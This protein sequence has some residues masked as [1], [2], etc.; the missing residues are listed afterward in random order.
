MGWWFDPLF[1][2]CCCWNWNYRYP[3]QPTST[4]IHLRTSKKARFPH[5]T[6]S[7]GCS[8]EMEIVESS[9]STH[10][11]NNVDDDEFV[12]KRLVNYYWDFCRVCAPRRKRQASRLVTNFGL[13]T[14]NDLAHQS[15]SILTCVGLWLELTRVFDLIQMRWFRA[16]FGRCHPKERL[17][18]ILTWK[19]NRFKFSFAILF[20]SSRMPRCQVV[21]DNRL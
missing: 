7:L 19:L 12:M 5:L 20:F 10:K 8:F 11:V 13:S 15:P 3:S 14:L 9:R 6:L 21:Y 16:R 18:D 2:R 1:V 4:L 17:S